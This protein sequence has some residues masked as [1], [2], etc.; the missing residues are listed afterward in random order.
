MAADEP[1]PFAYGSAWLR[2]DFHLHTKTDKEFSY[3]GEENSFVAAYVD[4]LKQAGI[5]LGVVTN[6]N[7]FNADEFKALRKKAS[8][9]LVR[10]IARAS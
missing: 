6:H 4:G 9:L 2:A 1:S 5:G 8:M 7:K 3:C 10:R